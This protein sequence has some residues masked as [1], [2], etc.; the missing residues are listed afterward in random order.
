[1]NDTYSVVLTADD[2]AE[3]GSRWGRPIWTPRDV[4]AEVRVARAPAMMSIAV[5]IERYGAD[6]ARE[7]ARLP[8]ARSR[9]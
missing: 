3:Q 1:M 2:Q 8:E 5:V 7:M 9:Q 6:L 4:P